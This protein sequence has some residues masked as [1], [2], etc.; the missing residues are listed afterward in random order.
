MCHCKLVFT[1]FSLSYLQLLSFRA[2]IGGWLNLVPV[3][4][5]RNQLVLFHG[6]VAAYFAGNQ[7]QLEL[8]LKQFHVKLNTP[9]VDAPSWLEEQ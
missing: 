9:G 3:K 8:T 6:A 1:D 4:V 2:L 7:K 5:L